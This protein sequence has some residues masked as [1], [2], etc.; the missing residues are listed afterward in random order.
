M[1]VGVEACWDGRGDGDVRFG[2]LMVV[3]I[4]SCAVRVSIGLY[5]SISTD[6]NAFCIQVVKYAYA[7]VLGTDSKAQDAD[8][9]CPWLRNCA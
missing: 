5:R 1:P 3:W 6:V 9:F 8:C 7:Y 2:F 4:T